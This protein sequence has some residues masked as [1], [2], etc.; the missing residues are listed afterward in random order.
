MLKISLYCYFSVPLRIILR[1]NII[2]YG[3]DQDHIP[4]RRRTPTIGARLSGRQKPCFSHALSCRAFEIIRPDLESHWRTDRNDAY[5]GQ[6][7]GETLRVGKHQRPGDPSRK[8]KLIGNVYTAYRLLEKLF[9]NDKGEFVKPENLMHMQQMLT[10]KGMKGEKSEVSTE[11]NIHSIT[12]FAKWLIEKGKSLSGR[13]FYKFVF[14]NS[15]YINMALLKLAYD[16]EP[17]GK[18]RFDSEN[19]KLIDTLKNKGISYVFLNAAK[20][21]KSWSNVNGVNYSIVATSGRNRFSME[22]NGEFY[23]FTVFGKIESPILAV[24][25]Y[26]ILNQ[27]YG[28]DF[29]IGTEDYKK[30]EYYIKRNRSPF[31]W[32]RYRNTD[33]IV[34]DGP[35]GDVDSDSDI[36]G[37]DAGKSKLEITAINAADNAVA[38][39]PDIIDNFKFAGDENLYIDIVND[40]SKGNYIIVAQRGGGNKVKLYYIPGTITS[41]DGTVNATPDE[42]RS[43]LE[44]TYNENGSTDLYTSD[45]IYT[46]TVRNDSGIN[47]YTRKREDIPEPLT[48]E[49]QNLSDAISE[50][51]DTLNSFIS[52]SSNSNELI[53]MVGVSLDKTGFIEKLKKVLVD[54]PSSKD[55]EELK[56]DIVKGISEQAEMDMSGNDSIVCSVIN[57]IVSLELNSDESKAINNLIDIFTNPKSCPF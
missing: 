32:G 31:E 45:K 24:Q 36:G 43:V 14:N 20:S 35:D 38:I 27:I 30:R 52:K 39:P 21:G 55:L 1:F 40:P 34:E 9:T 57:G 19:N 15:P 33:G 8:D 25:Y 42:I 54:N 23:P 53:K 51:K 50:N 44:K 41:P 7:V 3:K 5:I 56:N 46:F 49:L 13:D 18:I 17:S 16:I 29:G 10:P 26:D 37:T 2:N 28:M 12:E 11:K 6:F 47:V 22:I 48:Q 4:G